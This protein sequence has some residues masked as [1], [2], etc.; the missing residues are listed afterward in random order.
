MEVRPRTARLVLVTPD[1]IVVGVLPPVPVAVPWWSDV[2]SVVDAIRARDGIE[3]VILRLLETSCEEQP[4]GEVTYLAETREPVARVEAWTGALDEQPLRQSYAKPGGPQAD[5]AWAAR[6]LRTRGIAPAGAPVQ[7]RT[8]NLSSLWRIPTNGDDAW[9][10]VVPPFFAHEGAI[11]EALQGEGVPRLLGRD[12][13]R[14]LLAAIAGEDLREASEVQLLQMVALLVD[15]QRK[16]VDRTGDLLALGLPD[17]RAAPLTAAITDVVARTPMPHDES[18]ALDAFVAGLPERFRAVAA[19]G[20]PDTLVHGDFHP[21]NLRGDATSMT[22][23]DWGDSGVG[24]PLLDQPAFLDRAPVQVR[25]AIEAH[26][27]AAWRGAFPE[28]DPAR[29]AALLAP[30]AAARQ[31]VIYRR[32]LDNIEPSEHVY[33]ARDPA[34]WLKRTAE[35]LG[36]ESD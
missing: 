32:F 2:T 9:L 24:H 1:G 11:L 8:W 19:C 3:V 17:W 12:E 13:G 20:L 33:H 7:V 27:I 22:L 34:D 14:V 18:L 36:R 31:A 28:T 21:G 5:L 10:K 4:G 29:A 6:V 26:W 25:R 16:W 30:I 35:L 15:I 23:L